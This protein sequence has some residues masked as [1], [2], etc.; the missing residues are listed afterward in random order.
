MDPLLL[1][2]ISVWIMIKNI[3]SSV[4]I[5]LRLVNPLL[6]LMLFKHVGRPKPGTEMS[7]F[8]LVPT[9]T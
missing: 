4:S 8:R 5:L 2:Q 1:G 6:L 7:E 3:L 9:G